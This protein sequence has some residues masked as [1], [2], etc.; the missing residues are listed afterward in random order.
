MTGS[1]NETV[2]V[3][4]GN[5]SRATTVVGRDAR[6]LLDATANEIGSCERDA[7][8]DRQSD[9]G[10]KSTGEPTGIEIVKVKEAL[11]ADGIALEE[12]LLYLPPLIELTAVAGT[13]EKLGVILTRLQQILA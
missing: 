2:N 10:E 7:L 1:I 5:T 13:P 9:E 12:A 4:K 6:E 11:K 8:L 3:Q